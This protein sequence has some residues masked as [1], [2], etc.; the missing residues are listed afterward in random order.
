[1]KIRKIW[2]NRLGHL[3]CILNIMRLADIGKYYTAIHYKEV[4]WLS[5]ISNSANNF[6]YFTILNWNCNIYTVYIYPF[7][8]IVQSI[9]PWVEQHAIVRA[10]YNS[11]RLKL[12][13]SCIDCA[14]AR[15]FR[16]Q[17]FACSIVLY[18]YSFNM[19]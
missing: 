3:R 13:R 16:L 14:A 17:N 1:M 12:Y 5:S 7:D 8:I 2:K 4:R 6:K 10:Q 18:S 11:K 15:L 19:Q 9:Y